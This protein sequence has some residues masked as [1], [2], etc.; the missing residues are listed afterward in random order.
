ML[1][2]INEEKFSEKRGPI[3]LLIELNNKRLPKNEL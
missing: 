2:V 1:N 3:K